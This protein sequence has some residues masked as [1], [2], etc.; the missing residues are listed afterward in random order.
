MTLSLQRLRHEPP[1]VI[2][3]EAILL[4]PQVALNARDVWDRLV[5]AQHYLTSMMQ[6][7]EGGWCAPKKWQKVD[8]E[9]ARE[10]ITK[11]REALDVPLENMPKEAAKVKLLG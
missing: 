11:M 7:I 9:L 1:A 4:D 10:A 6:S 8:V 2:D 5:T 3:A